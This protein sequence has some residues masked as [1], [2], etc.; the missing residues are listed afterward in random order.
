MPNSLRNIFQT[1]QQLIQKGELE[2]AKSLLLKERE[3]VA[4]NALLNLL[5]GKI[6]SLQEEV[7][8]SLQFLWDAYKTSP[9]IPAII[10]LL[11]QQLQKS[12][13]IEQAKRILQQALLYS[14]SDSDILS[15]FADL[16]AFEA[17]FTQSIKAN[18][19]VLLIS[20]N[21]STA[22]ANIAEA[23]AAMGNYDEALINIDRSLRR[24]ND[25][26]LFLNR[27]ITLLSLGRYKDGWNAYEMRLNKDIP[28]SPKRLIRAPRWNH[29]SL[30]N[31]TILVCSEQGVGDELYFSAYLPW[32]EQI[33]GKV[34]LETDPRLVSLFR[35]SFKN[36]ATYPFSRRVLNKRPIYNY[37]WLSGKAYPDFFIDLASLPHFLSDTH[38]TTLSDAGYLKYDGKKSKAWQ[39]KLEY[40]SNG[41]PVVGLFWRSGLF[42]PE[43]QH[44]YPPLKLWE[45]ILR[46][47]NVSFLSLQYD[48]DADDI[49]LAEEA[50]GASFIKL[51]EVN[52]RDDF[53]EVGSI[54]S[55]LTGVISPSTTTAHLAAAV[56][57]RTVIIDQTKTWSPSVNGVDAI[58]PYIERIYP[59]K[60]GDW[61][62]VF[63]K[64]QLK[65][66]SW[67]Y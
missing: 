15:E 10:A 50:F 56:G 19:H 17:N 30:K 67:L 23:F 38:T 13:N 52:F 6:F 51:S 24:N 45:P 31:K 14:P 7:E 32:L 2:R 36:V 27:A 44:F 47:P 29:E 64:T 41:K 12:G 1:S 53:E 49:T 20:P 8:Q 57:T 28:T 40:L 9:T 11:S 58:L 42:T 16:C 4:T 61:K 65:L 54:C 21:N 66:A 63:N 55:A 62:W 35:R 37:G 60:Y 26:Q 46:T 25:S 34:I 43:R 33:S 22:H 5:L 48:H 3:N 39:Q 59:P 18:K